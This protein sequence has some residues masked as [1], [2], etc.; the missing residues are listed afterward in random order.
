MHVVLFFLSAAWHLNFRN[1][2]I[3]ILVKKTIKL[4]WLKIKVTW[5][6]GKGYS[7]RSHQG[8]RK[9][10]WNQTKEGGGDPMRHLAGVGQSPSLRCLVLQTLE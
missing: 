8:L 9:A 6:A 10:G 7:T 5:E 2:P 3:L 4:F 1:E